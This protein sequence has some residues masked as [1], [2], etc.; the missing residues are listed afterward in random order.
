MTPFVIPVLLSA[1]GPSELEPFPRPGMLP[2]SLKC[3]LL[4]LFFGLTR[5]TGDG[6]AGFSIIGQLARRLCNV[7]MPVPDTDD[8][9]ERG[10]MLDDVEVGGIMMLSCLL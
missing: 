8:E 7:L 6:L 5:L 2:C 4:C 3:C 1:F 9:S 10:E